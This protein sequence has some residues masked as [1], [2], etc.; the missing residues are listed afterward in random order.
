[1]RVRA[2]TSFGWTVTHRNSPD[3]CV[4]TFFKLSS[5]QSFEIIYPCEH[6]CVTSHAQMAMQTTRYLAGI[7]CCDVVGRETLHIVRHDRCVTVVDFVAQRSRL[8]TIPDRSHPD[9]TTPPHNTLRKEGRN[10]F[11]IHSNGNA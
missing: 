6:R 10:W 11:L 5:F 2:S 7:R 8:P 3:S 4:R 1:M 9:A